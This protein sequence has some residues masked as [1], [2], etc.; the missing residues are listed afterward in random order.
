VIDV[1]FVKT[2]LS[3][4]LD[5]IVHEDHRVPLVAVSVWYRV[6]SRNERPGLTGL[7]HLFE[8]L[9]FEGSA[10]QSEGYFAPLQEAGASLNGSTST[11]RT[12]Y[13][14][15]VPRTAVRLALWMEADRMGWLLPALTE[16]RFD[17]QRRVVLNERRQSY[18]NRPYGLAQFAIMEALFP[19]TH[20]YHWPTIGYPADLA[21]ATLDDV[22]A[23]FA[24]FYHP[25]N[26]SLAIA[27]DIGVD[28]ALATVGEF[29]GEIPGGVQAPDLAVPQNGARPARLLLE[30][31]VE[32][33]RLY[34]SW[35]SP[36]LFA[37]GDAELDLAGDLIGNGRSSRLYRRLIHDRRVAAELAAGQA[38]RQLGSTFQII[39]S[40]APGH[41]LDELESAI[42]EELD[43]FAH[44]GPTADEVA[45]GQAQ[46]E[47]SFVLRLQSLGGFGGKADQLNSYNVFLGAPDSFAADLN[48]Y[49]GATGADLRQAVAALVDRRDAVALSV[50]PP[51]RRDLAARD[52]IDV[53][54]TSEAS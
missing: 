31:R 44:E 26:A 17:T 54:W 8:H 47:S 12:N 42:S 20:P 51:G 46:A 36:A 11:D 41:T 48:R 5:V 43:R 21:Q 6:G 32:L 30:D 15:L 53:R 49:L 34:L 38:S 18:E 1:P 45:R 50:V 10:H 22:R 39:A 19:A 25:G 4:G 14:E 16:E 13:W 35:P 29:F 37:G 3:N 2:T 24:R 28:E 7:A 27:G 9:M 52:S 33:P 40:A 23:F